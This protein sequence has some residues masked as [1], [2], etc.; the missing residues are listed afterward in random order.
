MNIFSDISN[1][2]LLTFCQILECNFFQGLKSGFVSLLSTVYAFFILAKLVLTI[3]SV[4]VLS[5]SDVS[6]RIF[7]LQESYVQNVHGRYVKQFKY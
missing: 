7:K 2:F 4:L 6:W 5:L 3:V 1:I